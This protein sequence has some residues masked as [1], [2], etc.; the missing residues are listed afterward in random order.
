MVAA[1]KLTLGYMS[2][3][4]ILIEP[5]DRALDRLISLLVVSAVMRDLGDR[6]AF[7]LRTGHAIVGEFGMI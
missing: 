6:D 7:L 3:L 5:F 1:F 4:Q 2:L